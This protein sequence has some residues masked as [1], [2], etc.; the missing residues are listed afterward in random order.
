MFSRFFSSKPKWQHAKAAIR[1]SAIESFDGADPAQQ[2]ILET[3][4]TQDPDATVRRC[5]VTTLHNTRTLDLIAN[6]DSDERV[7]EA[8]RHQLARLLTGEAEGGPSA[9]QRLAEI[10]AQQNPTVLEHL[11]TH[12]DEQIKLAAL[13]QIDDEQQLEKI[14]LHHELA[15]VRAL[16]AER[17][18]QP[19]RLKNIARHS[20]GRDKK[21]YRIS[22]EKLS[23]MREQLRQ[24]EQLQQQALEICAAMETLART[25]FS[26]LFPPKLRGL[27]L[28]WEKLPHQPR[29]TE[30]FETALKRCEAI[31][32]QHD[33]TMA[34]LEAQSLAQR[35]LD[36]C[37]HT[38]ESQ[39]ERLCQQEELC[40]KTVEAVTALLEQQQHL[41]EQLAKDTNIS[42]T[43]QQRFEHAR[44][45]LQ[46]YNQSATLILAQ[47]SRLTQSERQAQKI[48]IP[49]DIDA[50]LELRKTVPPLLKKIDWPPIF[51]PPEHLNTAQRAMAIVAVKEREL[52]Q[53]QAQQL[54][55]LTSTLEQLDTAIDGGQLQQAETLFRQ[56]QQLF[57]QLPDHDTRPHHS[58]FN[59]LRARI[60]E[61]RDWRGFAGVQHK[62][63]LCQRMEALIH[64]E[65]AAEEKAILIKQLQDEWKQLGPTGPDHAKA[66]WQRFRE[67]GKRAYEP[68]R[69]FNHQQSEIRKKNLAV[70]QTTCDQLEDFIAQT[71]WE[72]VDWPAVEKIIAAAK[73]E[74]R[75]HSPV[76]RK[77]GKVLQTHFDALITQLRAQLKTEYQRNIEHKQQLLK[78][79]E[80]LAEHN[81]LGEAINQIKQLQ[82][83]WK[84]IGVTP[85]AAN[86]KIWQSFRQ[87][88][89]AVFARRDEVRQ[90]QQAAR[91]Q[92]KSRA[93]MLCEEV[94]ALARQADPDLSQSKGQLKQITQ[95][96]QALGKVP[97][98]I[99]K[100]F[101]QACENYRHH[102]A[103]ATHQH[104]VKQLAEAL[105]KAGLCDE[106]ERCVLAGEA[107]SESLL[108]QWPAT[109][110]LPATWE[111][112]L[113]ERLTLAQQDA[114]A[115]DPSR[116]SN[117]QEA[118]LKARQH[119]CI[120]AEILA[121]L[122]SPA[123]AKEARIKYQLECFNKGI[124]SPAQSQRQQALELTER[125]CSLSATTSDEQR[126]LVQRFQR[127]I[128]H[129][130]NAPAS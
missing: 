65:I 22:H 74:W 20:K 82:Q 88:S 9:A 21:V 41:W 118:S 2:E 18:E 17:I 93:Q 58:R 62:E 13:D 92:Q 67:A 8:A 112:A 10:E 87:A 78:Q 55:T 124:K 63:A 32:G 104:Q 19:E 4:A 89:D 59:Q 113:T 30:R 99:R 12:G 80:A 57:H 86:Q 37:C 66:L 3:L 69:D 53:W 34:E 73:E 51:T 61:L 5:A 50:L 29:Q 114:A 46:R 60:Q 16:A 102:L 26:A 101:D 115:K 120:E 77:A 105:R 38:L 14:A 39:I 6:N 96:F 128:S 108:E 28:Q 31:L 94:E 42:T 52:S 107:L 117:Q 100:R 70:R 11:L 90:A 127:A 25:E 40:G 36:S 23:R 27:V 7:R 47:A 129:C 79:A 121:E 116:L 44:Q 109:M 81:D 111:R 110:D 122:E 103:E 33:S 106:V 126:T 64:Q 125:W 68:C 72:T 83:Q 56:L 85:R 119:L 43:D 91:E 76:D 35:Q 54:P 71:N 45:L 24:E 75:R 130:L 97:D 95:A 123:E 48:V 84:A 15:K 98:P 1:L 49:Q